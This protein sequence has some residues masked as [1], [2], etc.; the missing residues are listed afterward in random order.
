VFKANFQINY[1][2]RQTT[3]KA[4]HFWVGDVQ[5]NLMAFNNIPKGLNTNFDFTHKNN[6]NLV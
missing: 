1:L 2:L 5:K 4:E 6:V 3:G